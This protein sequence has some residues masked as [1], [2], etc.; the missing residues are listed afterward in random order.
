MTA[1]K[2]HSP[3]GKGFVNSCKVV[4]LLLQSRVSPC[5]LANMPFRSQENLVNTPLCNVPGTVWEYGNGHEWLGLLV[6]KAS[7][8]PLEDFLQEHL[9]EPLGMANTT[10][11]PFADEEKKGR[12]MPLRWRE[13]TDDGSAEWQ[14]LTDQLPGLTLPRTCVSSSPPEAFRNV[15]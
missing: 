10:F 11:F 8:K 3:I 9:F 2:K 5:D 4:S 13:A 15:C 1:W 6:Q 7:G 12:L 14:V